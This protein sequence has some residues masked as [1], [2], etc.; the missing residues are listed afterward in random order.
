MRALL[1]EELG[2]PPRVVDVDEPTPAP[3]EA[4]LRIVA[5]PLN[6]VDVAIAT[7]RSFAGHP[8]LPY[9]PGVE[10]VARVEGEDSKAL[11]R[12]V[13]TCL[14]GLGTSRDGSC[15]ELATA[16]RD[17]LIP[18]PEGVDPG[19][20]AALGTVG[21]AA[22][23]PLTWR[24]PLSPG[25]NVLVLG[26]TG[27]VGLIAVQAARLLGASRVVAAGRRREGLERAVRYGADATVELV[28]ST[29]L[30]DSFRRACGS[31]GPTLVFD[32]VWGEPVVA[33]LEAAAPRAR[34][35][36]LGQA[37]G[38]NALVPSAL[39]RGKDLDIL[40][41]TNFNVPFEV[42][43]EGYRQ[44]GEHVREGR[45]VLEIENVSLEDGVGAWKRLQAG[46]EGKL[47]IRP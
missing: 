39:I 11:G 46:A 37:A 9:I 10:A 26:A 16:P 4:L 18:V 19:V 20:A 24:A 25:E 22:W 36:Q 43:A 34:I 15:A 1:I 38:A 44:L 17:R 12:L 2:R 30:A 14:H 28:D 45:I 31:E 35:I 27:T 42:L 47:V 5:A 29:T 41:Y 21:L 7:G 33:A 3:A 13:Y 8:R 23:L 40:G 32:S 6:P